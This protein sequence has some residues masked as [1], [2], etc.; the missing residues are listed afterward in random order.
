MYIANVVKCRPPDN[1]DPRP[2]E[3]TACRPYLEEQVSL[4]APKVVVTLGNFATRLLLDTDQ[5]I[6]KLRGA[7]YPVGDVQLV[8]TF[9]PAAALRGGG[10]VLAQMRADLV[11][12]KQLIGLSLVT[13]AGG[14][15]H[16]LRRG[17]PAGGRGPRRRLRPRRRAA[18]VGGL[19]AG[20]TTFAQGFGR[21]LGIDEPVTSP[22]FTL[23]RQYEVATRPT[24]VRT[25]FHA[26]VYRLERL[27]EIADLGLGQLVE[28]GGVALV[29][30][31][32]AA[33]PVLG[34]DALLLEFGGRRR[35]RRAADGHADGPGPSW[36]KRW[37]ELDAAVTPW[38]VAS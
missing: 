37:N 24:G 8:P 35:R 10:V 19:G 4:I 6:T 34:A 18:A 32:D 33:E 17:H 5:G 23:V 21:A 38:R 7:A 1:R 20:K 9:H 2:E 12:A 16:H 27:D 15:G 30:W 25:L 3:I 14:A 26:D 11:R 13:A 22:T 29:E 31:G 36:S 28:D